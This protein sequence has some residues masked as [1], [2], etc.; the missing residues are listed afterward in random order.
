MEVERKPLIEFFERAKII[1]VISE[2][3]YKFFMTAGQIEMQASA[4]TDG[5]VTAV[6]PVPW[7][8]P[9][10]SI[11]FDPTMLV[12]SLKA[13]SSTHVILG[14]DTPQSTILLT[15]CGDDFDNHFAASPRFE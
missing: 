13:M 2:I 10:M 1:K 5:A 9:D 14:F 12:D 4:G 15:E 3:N 7:T 6:L 11:P 8:W